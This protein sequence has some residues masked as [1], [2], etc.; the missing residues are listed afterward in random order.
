[1]ELINIDVEIR[2][3][4][5]KKWK[6]SIEGLT[7]DQRD[8]VRD[9]LSNL[10]IEHE[11]NISM[12]F[13]IGSVDETIKTFGVKYNPKQSP[14]KPLKDQSYHQKRI[15]DVLDSIDKKFDLLYSTNPIS[16]T[17]TIVGGRSLSK[18]EL[19]K[20]FKLYSQ[21]LLKDDDGNYIN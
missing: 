2:N 9:V 8:A 3:K 17:T 12:E 4:R 11:W 15:A 10:S 20:M 16:G 21:G 18:D 19:T 5:M 1:M 7:T 6:Y 14:S 13:E